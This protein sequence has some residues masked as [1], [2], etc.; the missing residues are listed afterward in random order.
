MIKMPLIQMAQW[1]VLFMEWI[2]P[3]TLGKSRS[4]PMANE[5]RLLE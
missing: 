3:N 1:G 5:T 4:R 2:L